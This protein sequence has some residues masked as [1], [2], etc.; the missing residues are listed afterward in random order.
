MAR[1]AAG[2]STAGRFPVIST[3]S[4]TY[5]EMVRAPVWSLSFHLPRSPQTLLTVCVLCA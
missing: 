1:A 4:T 5:R 2:G 3:P